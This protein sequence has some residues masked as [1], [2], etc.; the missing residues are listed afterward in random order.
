[1]IHCFYHGADFDGYCSGA[2]V[3]LA[4]NWEVEFYPMNHGDVF[5]W[6]KIQ[7]EDTV[8]VV[9]YVLS[10]F[11]DM[12]RLNALCN[13]IWIDHHGTAIKDY[14]NYMK[15]RDEAHFHIGGYRKVG[16]AACELCWKFFEGDAFMPFAIYMIG[17]Y[18]VWAHKNITDCLEFQYGLKQ[19]SNPYPT[20]IELWEKLIVAE[21]SND[22]F[23]QDIINKGST[24]LEYDKTRNA[25]LCDAYAFETEIDGHPAIALNKGIASSMAFESVWDN[26]KYDLMIAFYRSKGQWVVSLYTDKEGIDGSIVSKKYGGGG[27]V[28][29]SGFQCKELPFEH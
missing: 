20:N 27:H 10:P 29:A 14:D 7:P 18:D 1:M 5:P 25:K 21:D 28:G 11:V 26:E 13:L 12:L 24:V 8:Y 4:H 9:D 17:R 22:V 15:G 19:I 6:D 16:D 3:G 2:I 23:L